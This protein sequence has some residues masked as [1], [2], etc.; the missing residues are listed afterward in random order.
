MELGHGLLPTAST[1]LA[2]DEVVAGVGLNAA[3]VLAANNRV[4]YSGDMGAVAVAWSWWF[5]A[6][7]AEVA[8]PPVTLG[9]DILLAGAAVGLEVGD[10]GGEAIRA[11]HFG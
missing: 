8:S 6:Q 7:R 11:R 9:T 1:F 4:A 10:E 3:A 2:A 5:G